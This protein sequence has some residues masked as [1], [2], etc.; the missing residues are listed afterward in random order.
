MPKPKLQTETRGASARQRGP[1]TVW[2]VSGLPEV[3]PGDDLAAL[4]AA[5]AQS[6][7]LALEDDDVV[8]VAQKI[9]SKAEDA[10]VALA[11]VTPSTFAI[12]WGEQW[13]RDPRLVEL[14]LRES[15]R[16]VRMERG[17]IIAETRH[18]FVCANAGIDLSNT[19]GEGIAILL[20]EDPDRSARN[21]RDGLRKHT[22]RQVAVILADTF[23]RP[24]RRGLTQVAI[25]VAGLLPLINLR[26]TPD[27]DG[28]TLQATE[29]AAADQLAD[30]AELVIGK[31]SRLPV[32][33]VRNY[34]GPRGEGNASEL[35]R[36]AED[37]L[38]R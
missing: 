21:L 3:L 12:R 11:T 38:F 25:G 4:I 22:G 24:W 18:G 14:V 37:D 23:G 13:D 36:S 5:A 20:P 34:S 2:P 28:R 16:I 30:A 33:I 6:S 35:V 19:G 17:L 27:A 29:L 15:R 7:D 1:L 32:A 31:A 26:D 8:V 10:R 9:V